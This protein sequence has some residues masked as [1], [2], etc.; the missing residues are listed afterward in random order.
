LGSVLSNDV[1]AHLVDK[2]EVIWGPA[3][4][5]LVMDQDT[6]NY[7]FDSSTAFTGLSSGQSRDV[8]FRYR[9]TDVFGGTDEAI[10][11]ITVNGIDDVPVT[12]EDWYLVYEDD[13]LTMPVGPTSLLANDTS[14]IG[15]PP[16]TV[17]AFT[18]MSAM[19]AQVTVNTDGSFTYDPTGS[20]ALQA[21]NEEEYAVDTFTYTVEEPDGDTA[22]GTANVHVSGLNER[23]T[24]VD[25]SFAAWEGGIQQFS[26]YLL[27]NDIRGTVG[28]TLSLVPGTVTTA[29]GAT[30]VF[31]SNGSF[32]YDPTTSQALDELAE[33][34]MLHDTFSYTIMDQ[35]GQTDTATV[36]FEIY[37]VAD[38][39][40][41]SPDSYSA[42]EGVVLTVDAASGVLANDFTDGNVGHTIAAKPQVLTSA[43][44]GATLSLNADGS[45]EYDPTSSAVIEALEE[46]ELLT[47]S[48]QYTIEE[49]DKDTATA[50]IG[51]L[52]TGA[53]EPIPP[54]ANDYTYEG[55]ED[56]SPRSGM[57]LFSGNDDTLFDHVQKGAATDV[58]TMDFGTAA[59]S[60]IGTDKGGNVFVSENSAFIYYAPYIKETALLN[61]GESFTDTFDFTV[62]NQAGQSSTGTITLKLDGVDDNPDATDDSYFVYYNAA[63]SVGQAGGVLAND[64]PHVSGDQLIAVPMAVFDADPDKQVNALLTDLNNSATFTTDLGGVVTLYEDGSFTYDSTGVVS[65]S[66]LLQGESI[67]DSFDY[68]LL[69]E[70][71]N[72]DVGTV[73]IDVAGIGLVD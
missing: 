27:R 8:T 49:S 35:N 5:T 42:S 58:L 71:S 43:T 51:I 9:I 7:T 65:A 47:D 18:G 68:L 70:Y 33:G 16:L 19:G 57:R 4:G 56:T 62:E 73:S 50:E 20:A 15:T 31:Y 36:T 13:V 12:E 21:L 45:F 10:G 1:N 29:Y 23:P 14:T 22:T 3:Q 2:V 39:P 55:V 54:I 28:D 69:D 41:A 11:R 64:T 37:G 61:V 66:D 24:A 48:F 17:Q 34:E 6:G 25:D 46:G 52:V 60:T 63:M 59:G 30:V 44:T 53:A 32:N 26:N 67:T 40:T 72:G 38:L